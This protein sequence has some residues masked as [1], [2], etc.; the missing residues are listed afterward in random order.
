M[1]KNEPLF[2]TSALRSFH[3]SKYKDCSALHHGI[4]DEK[5]LQRYCSTLP[6]FIRKP[7]NREEVDSIFY[8]SDNRK[9]HS[10]TVSTGVA[11]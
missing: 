10:S 5:C 1:Y 7:I 11:S 8:K 2:A 9:I 3:A 6:S 4:N